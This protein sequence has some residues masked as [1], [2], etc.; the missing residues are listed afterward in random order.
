M[1]K[2]KHL[3]MSIDTRCIKTQ[4]LQ[5]FFWVEGKKVKIS[6]RVLEKMTNT[7]KETFFRRVTKFDLYLL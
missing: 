3:S 4:S 6:S 2:K 7:A 1:T 5:L